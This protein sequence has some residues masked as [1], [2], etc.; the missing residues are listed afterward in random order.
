MLPLLLA[1][2]IVRRTT[3]ERVHV[4]IAVSRLLQPPHLV[5]YAGPEK[6]AKRIEA[7][8]AWYPVLL[9]DRLFVYLLSAEPKTPLTPGKIYG[10]DILLEGVTPLIPEA[11][12]KQV[13]LRGR[14][15]PSF[16]LGRGA[17]SD[18][19]LL[20][21]SCR[22]LHGP[23][24]DMMKAADKILNEA[25][26]NERPEYLFLG[27]D[28]IYADDVH[29]AVLR[30]QRPL[31]TLLFGHDEAGRQETVAGLGPAAHSVTRSRKKAL[32]PFFT[33]SHM[34]HHLMTFAEY[35]CA[36]LLAWNA[37]LWLLLK[38]FA[39]P[40]T[41]AALPTNIATGAMHARR[42][43]ANVTTYMTF[44]DH[45][46]TDDW[47]RN[48]KWSDNARK[49]RAARQ[50]I[51]N[52]MAAY[53]AFQGWGNDPDAFDERFRGKISG[54]AE[55][56]GR[57]AD[58]VFDMLERS[59]WSFVAPTSPP[60]LFLDTR[61]KRSASKAFKDS[62]DHGFHRGAIHPLSPGPLG[63]GI[64]HGPSVK[65]VTRN[66]EAP[67]LLGAEER[68]RL[69]A[70][71]GKHAKGTRPFIVIAPAPIFG[72]PPAEKLQETIGK[73]APNVADLES[74]GANPRNLVDAVD[75][76]ADEA[77]EP[78]IVLSGDVHYGFEVAG[79]I[80]RDQTSF[81]F[82]QFCSSALKNKPLGKD[83]HG[84]GFLSRFW[85]KN[86]AY[87]YWEAGD[88]SGDDGPLAWMEVGRRANEVFDDLFGKRIF[89]VETRFFRRD[90]RT[91]KHKRIETQNNLGQLE[92]T[93]RQVWHR[94]WTADGDN[95][96]L[97][98]SWHAWDLDNWPVPDLVKL[99]QKAK[100]ALSGTQ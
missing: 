91:D 26:P 42:V 55:S 62:Y 4:W 94:H 81:P 17:G 64:Q 96:I 14:D 58:A 92:I 47:F 33:S 95:R 82:L 5:L 31:Q 77:P 15:R 21:G 84:L 65:I 74:W 39:E 53:W 89:T 32:K 40:A 97:A 49:H 90:G 30:F 20:Y 1:G 10:Y 2:P 51:A 69:R 68:A 19:R 48:E 87:H 41:L 79:R 83:A 76:F 59:D 86:R 52:G 13:V 23:E 100:R 67:R 36:Y 27:G 9:A 25:R 8:V 61:T 46:V 6:A 73:V 93:G 44:D 63:G 7:E 54:Y 85:N 38:P 3:P 88:G 18:I 34:D 50:I 80:W 66:P 75:L 60:T 24:P 78:L 56:F 72:Y 12:R 22:K 16:A 98:R 99:L 43:L 29:P 70:L 57:G 37:S 45:E 71:V 35:A 11:E 28:Q